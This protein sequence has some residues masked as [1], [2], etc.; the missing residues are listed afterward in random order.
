MASDD[1]T[2]LGITET[3]Y[4]GETL[5]G[6]N[7]EFE[8]RKELMKK[9]RIYVKRDGKV[10]CIQLSLRHMEAGSGWCEVIVAVISFKPLK[11]PLA[12]M[13]FTHVPIRHLTIPPFDEDASEI[14][15]KVFKFSQCGGDEYYPLGKYKIYWDLFVK[16]PRYKDTRIVYV[17]TGEPCTGKTFLGNHSKGCVYETDVPKSIPDCI[18]A[19]VVVLRNRSELTLE[20]VKEKIFQPAGIVVCTMTK[21]NTSVCKDARF[22]YV[23]TGESGIGKTYFASRLKDVEVYETDM[24]RSLPDCIKANVVVLGNRSKFTLEQVKEKISQPAEIVVCTMTK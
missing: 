6:H 17:L 13:P 1:M 3:I 15:N 8:V 22:V 12:H 5:D 2:V 23:L 21:N 16:T 10:M 20:Q 14:K 19:D 11:N 7:C 24:S 9:H 18:Y 4:V